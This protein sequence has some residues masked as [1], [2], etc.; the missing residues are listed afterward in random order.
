MWKTVARL[1]V[2]VVVVL[3]PISAVANTR[4]FYR[5]SY[6][7]DYQKV[8]VTSTPEPMVTAEQTEMP[9]AEPTVTPLVE[10]HL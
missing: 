7:S 2:L 1:A 10:I 9:T 8:E 5:K 6:R 4:L 3:L